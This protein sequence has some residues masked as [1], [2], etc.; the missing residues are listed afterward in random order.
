MT[1]LGTALLV[2]SSCIL[3]GLVEGLEYSLKVS[4]DPLDL[5]VLRKGSSNETTGGFETSKADQIL[6]LPGIQR[7]PSGAPLAAKELLNIANGERANGTRNNLIIR[8]V[9]PASRDLRPDFK[10]VPGR[11]HCQHDRLAAPPGGPDRGA[12]LLRRQ[13]AVPRRRHLHSRRQR[14]RERGLGRSQGRREEHRA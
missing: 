13:G 3:F 1:I 14:C 7:D 4:G 10:I 2:A 6:T 9:Q 5:I 11:V 12:A 8:G